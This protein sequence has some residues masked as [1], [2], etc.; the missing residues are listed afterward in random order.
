MNKLIYSQQ[1]MI[2]FFLFLLITLQGCKKEEETTT[3]NSNKTIVKY[4][5]ISPVAT[6][7]DSTLS[8]LGLFH[9]F[10]KY[11]DDYSSTNG[12]FGS[13]SPNISYTVW[14]KE[15][16]I[17]NAPRPFFANL[18]ARGYVSVTSGAVKMNIYVN[19]ALKANINAP[20]RESNI[21]E[22]VG[23]FDLLFAGG[24]FMYVIE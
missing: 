23:I 9:S 19:G 14:T 18:A 3:T 16:D 10:L 15:V 5:I 8:G 24:N 21:Q 7:P 13:E 4:E 11:A 1:N 17:T 20:I 6:I 2:M 12:G 22:G